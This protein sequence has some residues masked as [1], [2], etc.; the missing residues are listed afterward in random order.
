MIQKE[1]VKSGIITIP[2][3]CRV[4][5][6]GITYQNTDLTKTGHTFENRPQVYTPY[7]GNNT[8]TD[9]YTKITDFQSK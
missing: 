9:N 8:H 3:K 1:L 6:D 2:N 5:I 4:R 7:I